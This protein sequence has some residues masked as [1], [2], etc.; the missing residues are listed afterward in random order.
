MRAS[1]S[2]RD[3]YRASEWFEHHDNI[4]KARILAY[5]SS[6]IVLTCIIVSLFKALLRMKRPWELSP[7]VVSLIMF[8]FVGDVELDTLTSYPISWESLISPSGLL[9]PFHPLTRYTG[10]AA[11]TLVMFGFWEASLFFGWPNLSRLQP[12]YRTNK[13]MAA[14]VLKAGIL[15]YSVDLGVS[16]DVFL[17]RE[18]TAT[19]SF[20]IAS[21]T[22]IWTVVVLSSFILSLVHASSLLS[23]AVLCRGKAGYRRKADLTSVFLDERANVAMEPIYLFNAVNTDIG[24]PQSLLDATGALPVS[25]ASEESEIPEIPGSDEEMEFP[26]RIRPKNFDFGVKSSSSVPAGQRSSGS[27]RLLAPVRKETSIPPVDIPQTTPTL[28]GFNKTGK[29]SMKRRPLPDGSETTNHSPLSP[30]SDVGHRAI[31]LVVY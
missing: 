3:F 9:F 4:A 15:A 18:N 22:F 12:Y 23:K 28:G 17:Q 8:H 30:P 19:P 14:F 2:I 7:I 1:P 27:D 26:K 24:R 16:T 21:F 11:Y 20:A 13:D 25:P 10:P 5:Y 29:I 31:N 6:A